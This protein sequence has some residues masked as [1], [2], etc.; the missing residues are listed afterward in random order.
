[1]SIVSNAYFGEVLVDGSWY[2]GDSSMSMSVGGLWSEMDKTFTWN[3]GSINNYCE[4][5]KTYQI[6]FR[7]FYDNKSITSSYKNFT[8]NLY[9]KD[10][11]ITDPS[12]TV[13][14]LVDNSPTTVVYNC[15]TTGSWKITSVMHFYAYVDNPGN[16]CTVSFKP[17][18]AMKIVDIS[19][20]TDSEKLGDIDKNMEEQVKQQVS[21]NEIAKETQE[22]QKNFFDNFFGN[23]IDS[24]IGVFVPEDGYF[25]EY[26]NR[27]NDFFAERF[28][29]LYA[30]ID[31]MVQFFQLFLNIGDAPVL[32]FPGFSIMGYT[33]WEPIDVN[34]EEI[35]SQFGLF[36]YIRLG[37]D[38]III[39]SF[40]NFIQKKYAEVLGQ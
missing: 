24:L 38:A 14:N 23:L 40:L 1:M 26:F 12:G 7:P 16:T 8:Y 33:V 6:T 5:G 39:I 13:Y 27:L 15:N 19:E 32:T 11:T 9:P 37:G 4:V 25:S 22:Q 20:K 30:P 18:I 3:F 28:G 36:E 10:V 21:G 17:N 29:F 2:W 34:W 31:F 35:V